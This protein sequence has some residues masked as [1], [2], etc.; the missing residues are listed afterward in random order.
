MTSV[1]VSPCSNYV[2]SASLDGY[3]SVVDIRM[4]IDKLQT[5]SFNQE[6][7]HRFLIKIKK[8]DENITSI[9]INS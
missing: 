8:G 5:N 6:K 1:A 2:V 9:A 3:I 7:Y 4:S